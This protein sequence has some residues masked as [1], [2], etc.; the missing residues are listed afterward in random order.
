MRFLEKDLEDIIW[1]NLFFQEDVENLNNR[2][3]ECVNYTP[4][5]SRQ[6]RIGNYGI[7]DLITLERGHESLQ[8]N[9]YELKKDEVNIDG[10][11]QLSRYVTGCKRYL[12]SRFPEMEIFIRPI[13]IGRSIHN[14]DWVYLFNSLYNTIS[15][16]TYEYGLDGLQFDLHN[17]NYSLIDE[18][19]EA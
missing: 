4:F 6:L 10:I 8:V 19:F 17:M 1:D 16:Y 12:R 5:K 7:C 2:G 9:I 18:G 15:V 14:G 13:I 11:I 3:L